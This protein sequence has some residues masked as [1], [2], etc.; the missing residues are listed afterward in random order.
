VAEVASVIVDARLERF[1]VIE[2]YLGM[3]V[4][5][6]SNE[7]LDHRDR[8]SGVVKSLDGLTAKTECEQIPMSIASL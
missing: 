2:Y 8:D 3:Q 1:S 4:C 5:K 7:A 6:R